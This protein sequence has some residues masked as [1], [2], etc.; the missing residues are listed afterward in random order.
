M[1][2]TTLLSPTQEAA[3]LAQALPYIKKFHGKTI[4]VKYGGN[5]MTDENL[6]RCFARDVVLLKLVGMN[7]VVVHGGGPQIENLLAR[8]GKKGEFIQGMRVTDAETM[9]AVEMVLGGQVNKEIVS[10]INQQGGKAVGLTGKDGN[11]IHAKKLLLPNKDNP[12]E[13]ID[14]GQVGDITHIDPS[15][16]GHLES[17]GFIPVIAPVGVGKGGETYNINA[18]VVAGKIAEVLKA[19]KLVL[20]TNTPGVLDK[21]GNLL[22]G[23]TPKDIDHMVEDGTLSGGMLPKIGSALD[24]AR[25]GVKSVHIIDGRV[26]HAL[27]LEILTDHGVG[28]MIKS[29]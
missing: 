15:L 5:A 29:H 22:T 20:L 19:E 13:G 9:E 10:L 26:A 1:T 2:E 16:I 6:K 3:V 11:F 8:I 7:V 24:A 12:E 17:G 21:A 4:V 14:V 25:N 18:D 23:I 28:T 27:L